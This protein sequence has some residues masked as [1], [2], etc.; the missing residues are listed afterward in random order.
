[1]R[2]RRRLYNDAM[3]AA[4]RIRETGQAEAS[5]VNT[6]VIAV[7]GESGARRFWAA[8]LLAGLTKDYAEVR[9][10][11]RRLATAEEWHLR[12]RAMRCLDLDSP[13]P[14]AAEMVRKGLLD[15]HPGVRYMAAC[16]GASLLLTELVEDLARYHRSFPSECPRIDTFWLPLL[17]DGYLLQDQGGDVLTLWVVRGR[18]R[19]GWHVKREDLANQRPADFI[20]E[21]TLFRFWQLVL[22]GCRQIFLTTDRQGTLF[23]LGER[24]AVCV[25][26]APAGSA[27][28]IAAKEELTRWEGTWEGEGGEKLTFQG[29]HW[30]SWTP[31]CGPVWGK[32]MVIEVQEKVTLVDLLTE[33][34]ET[35]RAIVKAIIRV[36]GNTLEYSGTCGGARPEEF[37]TSDG[38]AYYVL[39]RQA[40]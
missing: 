13:R 10:A 32:V 15:H 21:R 40:K 39:K 7:R 18:Q 23:N 20:R 1:M 38:I 29:D 12:R 35:A 6:L 2:D 24:V 11:V 8:R 37:E 26:D 22:A 4:A 14:F 36:E 34:G 16:V 33:G 17:R 31:T 3:A 25:Q 27:Q 30:E 19:E 5:L 28:E 9:E